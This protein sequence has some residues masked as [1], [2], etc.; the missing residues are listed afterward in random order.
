[1]IKLMT[2]LTRADGV[3]VE[4][5]RDYWRN[6]EGPE[7]AKAPGVRRYIQSHAAPEFYD[8]DARPSF[9]GLSEIWF[10]DLDAIEGARARPGWR[11]A[12]SAARE[13]IG[14]AHNLVATEVPMIDAFPDARDRQSMLKYIGVLS[15]SPDMTV[16]AF[17][18]YWRDVHGPLVI[19]SLPEMRHYVQSHPLPESYGG[20][21]SPA[22]DGL[23][24]AWFEALE[25]YPKG[26]LRGDGRLGRDNGATS[27]TVNFIR[28]ATSLSWPLAR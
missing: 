28:P 6:V 4:R 22:F 5:F 12:V 20:T 26:I 17:Q 15:R 23:P 2:L 14:A 27:D 18:Q 3:S 13:V 24:E 9:D 19:A 10:D 11:A 21:L 16:E 25:V 8:T 7:L 1:M